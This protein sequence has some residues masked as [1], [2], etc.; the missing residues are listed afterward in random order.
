VMMERVQSRG[1]RA[2]FV[3]FGTSLGGGHHSTTFD[4]DEEVIRVGA[5]FLA[6]MQQAVTR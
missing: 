6:A 4:V 5:E 3:L 1:G 2:L